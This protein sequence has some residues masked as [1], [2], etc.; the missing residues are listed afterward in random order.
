MEPVR[1]C[2][3]GMAESWWGKA[4]NRNLESYSDYSNRLPRGRSY[5]RQGAVVDLKVSEGEVRAKVQGS[6]ASPYDVKVRISPMSEG[7]REAVAKECAGKVSNLE[8]LVRGDFPEDLGEYFLSQNGL[9]PRPSEISFRCSCPDWASMCKHVAA[10]LYGIGRRFD[11]DPT[12]FFSLRGVEM[13]ELIGRTARSKMEA[14]MRNA[15]NPSSRILSQDRMSELFGFGSDDGDVPWDGG[16]TVQDDEGTQADDVAS[17]VSECIASTDDPVDLEVLL[18]LKL[19]DLYHKRMEDGSDVPA[20]RILMD[21]AMDL[22][23]A[24]SD[25]VKGLHREIDSL[26]GWMIGCSRV[27]DPGNAFVPP[28]K[29]LH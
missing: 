8:S 4:W 5:M 6:R 3:R 9:F 13:E 16:A 2:G 27:D 10:V 23:A 29:R 19:S 18:R 7:R 17:V 20:S 22:D 15:D 1:A 12:L 26:I 28:S 21:M 11:Q 25:S 24:V 14:M